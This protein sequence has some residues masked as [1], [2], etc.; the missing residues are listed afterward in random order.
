LEKKIKINI[1]KKDISK[2]FVYL[3][4]MSMVSALLLSNAQ[5]ATIMT[6]LDDFTGDDTQ[7]KVTID[8]LDGSGSLKITA[9]VLSPDFADIRGLFFHIS[10]ESLLSGLSLSI[11]GDV[12]DFEFGPAN[13]VNNLGGGNNLNGG[14]TPC[15]PGCDLGFEIGTPGIGADDFSM[16][17]FT[18]THDISPLDLSLFANQLVGV[19][20]TSVGDSAGSREGSSKLTGTFPD[21]PDIIISVPEPSILLLFGFGLTGF[22]FIMRRRKV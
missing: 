4:S 5:A 6:T 19:R 14:G 21:V 20:L 13:S 9:E 2:V 1:N 3:F 22:G 18:L 17:M 12:T 16:T 10:D 7:V 15:S 11:V 8:D